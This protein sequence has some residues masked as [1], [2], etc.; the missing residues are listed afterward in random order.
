MKFQNIL[1][2][3]HNTRI[4]DFYVIVECVGV[5]ILSRVTFRSFVSESEE[6][7]KNSRRLTVYRGETTVHIHR[8]THNENR[9]TGG[10][11]QTR[12]MPKLLSSMHPLSQLPLLSVLVLTLR[13]SLPNFPTPPRPFLVLFRH[14]LSASGHPRPSVSR[15]PSCDTP[16]L[17]ALILVHTDS[18]YLRERVYFWQR[19]PCIM[20]P[21][22]LFPSIRFR[23]P[24]I[25]LSLVRLWFLRCWLYFC[26]HED[27]YNL[28]EEFLS[29]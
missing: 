16:N 29:Y 18:G 15:L 3:A 4:K 23:F 14:A 2:N 5:Q 13:R 19:L 21:Q 24:V 7:R 12:R 8:C 9:W 22:S 26:G 25:I 1:Y 10:C 28:L 20:P 17:Y 11:K 27:A 6:R